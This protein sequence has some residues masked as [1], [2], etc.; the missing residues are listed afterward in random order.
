MLKSNKLTLRNTLEKLCVFSVFFTLRFSRPSS[1]KCFSAV[2]YPLT[3]LLTCIAAVADVTAFPGTDP[4][5]QRVNVKQ[6]IRCT[7]TSVAGLAAIRYGSFF[8]QV[9]HITE[10]VSRVLRHKRRVLLTER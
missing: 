5:Q 2:R 4:Q 9:P 10:L 3:H 1:V 6:Q 7:L 8:L